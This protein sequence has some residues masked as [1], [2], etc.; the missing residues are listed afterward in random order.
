M[1]R[2]AF[3]K[4]R[5]PLHVRS[6]GGSF[7]IS[8][9]SRVIGG[10]PTRGKTSS[11]RAVGAAGHPAA[12]LREHNRTWGRGETSRI[13]D[14]AARMRTLK[15]NRVCARLD[16]LSCVARAILLLH[17]TFE[18]VLLQRGLE[19]LHRTW[20]ACVSL[21]KRQFAAHTY[22]KCPQAR[23]LTAIGRCPLPVNPTRVNSRS[24]ET[25]RLKELCTD[26][27]E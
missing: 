16:S 12:V 27:K 3:R 26:G 9:D 1:R 4:S 13:R 20:I 18:Q 5:I 19:M 7:R 24:C 21:M 2:Q 8:Q 11:D 10:S 22:T 17:C 25:Y 15:C 14:G 23:G 6:K